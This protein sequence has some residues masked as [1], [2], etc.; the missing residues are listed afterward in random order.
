MKTKVWM[1]I[2]GVTEAKFGAGM[3]GRTIQ[4]LPHPGIHPIKKTTKP[5]HYC[6]Y[7]HDFA[8]RT[9]I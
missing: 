9:L 5:R 7:Q 4:R 3:E 8:D 2:E 1:L 6:I